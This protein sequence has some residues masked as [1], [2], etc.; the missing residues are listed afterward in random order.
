MMATNEEEL[1]EELTDRLWEA[2]VNMG[3][4]ADKLD[5]GK[6]TPEAAIIYLR[7]RSLTIRREIQ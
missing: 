1:I 7:A 3:D 6:I 5:E 4:T 2:A